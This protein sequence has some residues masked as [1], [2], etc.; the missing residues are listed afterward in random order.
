MPTIDFGSVTL[1]VDEGRVDVY[2]PFEQGEVKDALKQMNGRWNPDRRCWTV[3]PRFARRSE[4]EIAAA[5]EEALY[6]AAPGRWPDAVRK[7]SGYACATKRYEVKFGAGGIRVTLPAGHPSHF[8]LEHMAGAS[9]K[10]ETWTIP[11]K[12][13]KTALVMPVVERAAKEDRKAFTDAVE[14][15]EGRSMKGTLPMSPAAADAMGLVPGRVVFAEYQF[16]KVVDPLVVNMPVHCWPFKVASR[17][18]SPGEGYE[19]LEQGVSL[20]LAYLDSSHGYKA[21]RKLQA[22]A[23]ED[24]PAKLDK[25]HA[26]GKWLCRR[27]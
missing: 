23:E 26:D 6:A 5:V 11:A 20:K 12:L 15:Y 2:F 14:P 19:H 25:P 22:M 16:L 18:D 27:G 24:R 13:A 17:E 7:F 21:V 4:A 9:H 1:S 8:T 10:G 3:L